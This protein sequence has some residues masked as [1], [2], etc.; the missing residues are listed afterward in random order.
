MP[1]TRP[2][3]EL[4]AYSSAAYDGQDSQFRQLQPSGRFINGT[5]DNVWTVCTQA[6]RER[7]FAPECIL[8]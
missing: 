2:G 4:A 7:V 6:G 5:R 3:S 8:G 1:A